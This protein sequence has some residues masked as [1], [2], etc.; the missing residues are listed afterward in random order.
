MIEKIYV[1]SYGD[2]DGGFMDSIWGDE[3]EA[4]KRCEKLNGT[5]RVRYGWDVDEY[6]L[7]KETME[8]E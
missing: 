5:I 2:E 4:E 6:I 3:N 7:N 8:Y 1:V